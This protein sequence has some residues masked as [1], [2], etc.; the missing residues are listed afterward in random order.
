MR[1]LSVPNLIEELF[2][3]PL[4]LPYELIDD[5]GFLLPVEIAAKDLVENNVEA[6]FEIILELLILDNIWSLREIIRL[7]VL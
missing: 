7:K 6:V 1:I 4:D 5:E 3:D 2:V